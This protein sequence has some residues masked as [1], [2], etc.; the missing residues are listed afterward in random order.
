MGLWQ[1]T[2]AEPRAVSKKLHE[3]KCDQ[4]KD[5]SS[6]TLDVDLSNAHG[7]VWYRYRPTWIEAKPFSG[8]PLDFPIHLVLVQ[9]GSEHLALYP[10]S[11]DSAPCHL[12]AS[13]GKWAVDIRRSTAGEGRGAVVECRSPRALDLKNLVREAINRAQSWAGAKG[14]PAPLAAHN[15]LNRL[16]FCTWS[17]LGET[18]HVSRA[19]FSSLLTELSAAKIPVQAFVIDD[20]WQDQQHRQLW[21]FESNESFGDLGEAVSLVK[22]TFEGP[23]VGG[24]DVG[25]WLALNGGYWNGVHPDSPLVEKYGCKPFKYSNPYD[26]GEYWV[27]TKPEFWSDWFAW[28]KSQGVS[29]LKVD[30]Q[31]SLTFLHGIQGAEVATQVYTLMLAAADATF[32]PGRVVHS[33]AHSSSFF[34]GRAGFS[35]QSF[36]WRNSDDFGMIHELRNAHQIFVFSNLSNA[37]VSNHL[38]T[39]P[40]ADM[41]M[42]AAQYPQSH[43]VLRAMFPGPVLLSDKPA[44]HDTKLLGRLIAYDAQGEV[45]VVKCESAAELLPRRLMDT[46]ILDDEDGTATWAAVKCGNGALLAAFNCRDVGRQ[47]KDKLKHEDVE[48]AMALA[49]LAGDVVVLRY[50]LDEGALTAGTLFKSSDA[51]NDGEEEARRPLQD[52]HLHEMGVALWRVVPAGRKQTWGLVGQFAGLNCTR[53]GRYLYSGTATAQGDKPLPRLDGGK[54]EIGI[55]MFEV[56]PNDIA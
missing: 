26:S 45:H 14:D 18:N 43:A 30:N 46:S 23:E 56:I 49:G 32:G 27:P 24:C 28:L 38:S 15:P 10:V 21:S 31:A 44:E 52:V 13:K 25:V 19:M 55:R 9:Q 51:A 39:V 42:T 37:L 4:S 34:N 16:G 5:K 47:V 17:A 6:H 33:M 29:F 20:G 1:S 48:D 40:D 8:R 2:P 36:V 35:K 11:S 22:K 12:T 7:W 50:D 3:F 53:K 54:S 41:F